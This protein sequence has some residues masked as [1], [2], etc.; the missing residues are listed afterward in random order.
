MHQ[1]LTNLEELDK[2][3]D[4]KKFSLS[5]DHA[6]WEMATFGCLFDG[7]GEKVKNPV[8]FIYRALAQWGW[9]R[10]HAEFKSQEE[11]LLLEAE[12][13]LQRMGELQEKVENMK[14]EI[15]KKSLSTESLQKI[16]ENR[17]GPEDVWLRNYYREHAKE[18]D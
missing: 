8:S 1:A 4:K 2:K 15:W 7:K 13:E 5:L 9:F 18:Q 6:E 17:R 12:R 14:F 11:D 3:A 10:A 16:M